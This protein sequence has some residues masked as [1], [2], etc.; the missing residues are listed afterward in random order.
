MK[1]NNKYEK[2]SYGYVKHYKRI[3]IILGSICLALILG[4]LIFSLSVFHTK[5]TLFVVVGCIMA[6]PFARNVV[7]FILAFPYKS[8]T[9]DEHKKF[10]KLSDELDIPIL[11]DISITET[12]GVAFYQALAIY[13]NN[14]IAFQSNAG[15][16]KVHDKLIKYLDTAQPEG[17]SRMR[18]VVTSDFAQFKKNLLRLSKPNENQII[19]DNRARKKVLTMGF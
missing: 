2:G 14:F 19:I 5:K 4:D 7:D 17:K 16:K 8:L 13:N 15:D 6:I 9:T 18:L 11:Y 1:I 12:E 10:E 3:R